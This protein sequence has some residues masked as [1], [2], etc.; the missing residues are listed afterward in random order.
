VDLTPR[1][2][3]DAAG[4]G[5]ASP[6]KPKR[7]LAPWLFLGFVVIAGG[8][9]M[10]QFL[11]SAIDYYCNVDEI[12]VKEQCSGDRRVRI[13]GRVEQDSLVRGGNGGIESFT[14]AF[15]GKEM[16]VDYRNGAALPDLFQECIPVVVAGKLTN[17]AFEGST[18]DVK[19]SNEYVAENGERIET[20]ESAACELELA[21]G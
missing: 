2:S 7:R 18:V 12:G 6:A 8:V 20:A 11:T 9:V 17:G 3:R 16:P 4:S 5:S 13:Q 10:T 1:T 14:I 19:H 21:A 15:N